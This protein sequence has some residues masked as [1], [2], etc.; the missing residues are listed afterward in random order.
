VKL[1]WTDNHQ[2]KSTENQRVSLLLQAAFV[3]INIRKSWSVY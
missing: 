2:Q 1:G 3:D